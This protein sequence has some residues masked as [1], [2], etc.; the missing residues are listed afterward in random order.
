MVFAFYLLYS[1]RLVSQY[2][3][4]IQA[5]AEEMI[6]RESPVQRFRA[7]RINLLV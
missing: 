2:A 6:Y 7:L 1:V 5:T 4:F 3:T